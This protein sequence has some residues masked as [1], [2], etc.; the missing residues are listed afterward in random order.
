[1]KILI[2]DDDAD[3]LN[4]LKLAISKEEF[5]VRT[6]SSVADALQDLAREKFDIVLTDLTID[7]DAG[8]MELTAAINEKYPDIDVI[9]LTGCPTAEAAIK[10]IKLGIYDYLTKPMEIKLVKAALRRCKEKRSL[11]ARLARSEGSM[12]E[13][14]RAVDAVSR[15]IADIHQ[16]VGAVDFGAEHES[17]HDFADR[18]LKELHHTVKDLRTVLANPK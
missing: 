5:T 16:R 3:T 18:L 7:L 12:G 14:S 9:M 15:R 4:I 2:V 6:A 8:G 1:M 13:A 11:R 17:C 10:A